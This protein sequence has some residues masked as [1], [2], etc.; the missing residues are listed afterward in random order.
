MTRHTATGI[1][2]SG[3]TNRMLGPA[4]E[5]QRGH[6]HNRP[7]YGLLRLP[8]SGLCLPLRRP[9]TVDT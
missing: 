1:V 3:T 8:H 9:Q 4:G 5:I 6:S 7:V 2:A